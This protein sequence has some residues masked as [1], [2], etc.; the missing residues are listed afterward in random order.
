MKYYVVSDEE[1]EELVYRTAEYYRDF[2][3]D[4]STLHSDHEQGKAEAACRA[5]PVTQIEMA[6]VDDGTREMV[7]AEYKEVRK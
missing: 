3:Q 7:W 2:F 1:L 5:R 6:D 4:R